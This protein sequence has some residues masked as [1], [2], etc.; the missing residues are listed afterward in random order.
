MREHSPSLAATDGEPKLEL[1]A[2]PEE[3]LELDDLDEREL[4][5]E[6]TGGCACTSS[7]GCSS[8]SCVGWCK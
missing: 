8:C 1:D 6:P 5:C 7:C 2:W 4:L 3:G